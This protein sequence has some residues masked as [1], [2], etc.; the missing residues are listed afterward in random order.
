MPAQ[1]FPTPYLEEPVSLTGFKDED[2]FDMSFQSISIQW[3]S[4]I[5]QKTDSKSEW[6]EPLEITTK[7]Q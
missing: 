4:T 5:N 7:Q 6:S 3:K 1:S 2:L